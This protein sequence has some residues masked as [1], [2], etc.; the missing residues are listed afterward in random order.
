MQKQR[1]NE[2]T[3]HCVFILA[4]LRSI[5]GQSVQKNEAECSSVPESESLDNV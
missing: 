3:R 1:W 4:A 5:F 2:A